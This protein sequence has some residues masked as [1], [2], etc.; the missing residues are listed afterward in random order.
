MFMFNIEK[1]IYWQTS[2]RAT[3]F[4]ERCNVWDE[5]S[6]VFIY[7]ECACES[8]ERHRG[9]RVVMN[10]TWTHWGWWDVACVASLMCCIHTFLL[11]SQ[12]EI[13]CGHMTD[14]RAQYWHCCL[15]TE[16]TAVVHCT[17]LCGVLCMWISTPPWR[18]ENIQKKTVGFWGILVGRDSSFPKI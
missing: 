11:R 12:E 3:W 10:N 5:V 16:Y 13:I 17:F 14:L 9:S 15:P 18:A 6:K 7:G 2:W 1:L 4:G 8:D